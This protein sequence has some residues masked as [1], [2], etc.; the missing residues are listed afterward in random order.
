MW[1]EMVLVLRDGNLIPNA[2][3]WDDEIIS[4]ILIT[5]NKM[6]AEQ[7][8]EITQSMREDIEKM[9]LNE[10][11]LPLLEKIIDAKMLEYGITDTHP[12]HLN[13][14]SF[15][16]HTSFSL[17]DNAHKVLKKRYLKKDSNGDTIETADEMFRRVAHHI[18]K[19]ENN[20][21]GKEQAQKME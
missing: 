15:A 9:G 1:A 11:K 13:S 4:D 21:A 17:S 14:L 19:A 3:K 7:A 16:K 18:A 12:I 5:H 10:I 6:K 8:K 2:V 20:Y